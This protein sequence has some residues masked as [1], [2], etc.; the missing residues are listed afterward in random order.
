MIQWWDSWHS[1][2][3][4]NRPT[5]IVHP[6][7]PFLFRRRFHGRQRQ[8]PL[9]DDRLHGRIVLQ[10]RHQ[11]QGHA[12]K[13]LVALGQDVRDIDADVLPLEKKVGHDHD[14]VDP[15]RGQFGNLVL[16]VRPQ[17][18]KEGRQDVAHAQPC[19]DPAHHGDEAFVGRPQGTA[20]TD[21]D[22]ARGFRS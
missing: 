2:H 18:G 20:V 3:P 10:R 14:A 11:L 21:D 16:D 12:G 13:P 5:P 19:R 4:S 22:Q 15:A 8:E 17:Q 9:D 6:L 1:A 7:F